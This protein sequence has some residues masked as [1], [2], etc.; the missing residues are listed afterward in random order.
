ML[1]TLI[2]AEADPVVMARVAA[3]DAEA[4]FREQIRSELG[5]A[6]A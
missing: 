5:G 2:L 6:V 1:P 4:E 3:K